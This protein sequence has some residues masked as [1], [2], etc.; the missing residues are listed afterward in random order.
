MRKQFLLNIAIEIDLDASMEPDEDD[1]RPADLEGVLRSIRYNVAHSRG[2]TEMS[3]IHAQEI[4]ASTG[5]FIK[6][7]DIG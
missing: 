3:D 5:G 4:V 7:W 1:D 6:R 2:V